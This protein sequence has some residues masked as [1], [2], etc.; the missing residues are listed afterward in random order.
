M[1]ELADKRT[2]D[3][4]IHTRLENRL[5][6]IAVE[7]LVVQAFKGTEESL[8]YSRNV[9]YRI[10]RLVGSRVGVREKSAFLGT[11]DRTQST[12]AEQGERQL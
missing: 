10:T 12:D 6:I 2:A 4:A 7:D 1:V 11:G 5:Q 8:N 9:F 3:H